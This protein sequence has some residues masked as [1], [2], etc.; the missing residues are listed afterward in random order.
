MILALFLYVALP[1]SV[2]LACGPATGTLGNKALLH[3]NLAPP[4]KY[5]YSDSPSH[6]QM[7]SAQAAESNA[8]RDLQLAILSTLAENG[9]MEDTVTLSYDYKAPKLNLE[10]GQHCTKPNT[11]VVYDGAILYK[12]IAA[13]ARGKRSRVKRQETDS[14]T[15]G[16]TTDTVDVTT[17]TTE[18]TTTASVGTTE[19]VTS[20]VT[21]TVSVDPQTITT[22]SVEI[23]TVKTTTENVE[24]TTTE[25]PEVTTT[26]TVPDEEPV[27]TVEFQIIGT[28][29]VETPQP[30]FESQWKSFAEKIQEKLEQHHVFFTGAILVDMF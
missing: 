18:P 7:T 26:T 6:G 29:T 1:A 27:Q 25:S 16:T 24:V 13:T 14:P 30:I 2:V 28:V 10:A 8:D 9:I 22:K 5:T 23:T 17:G 15:E 20:T 3:F 19:A 12:C 11:F 21:T 4:P